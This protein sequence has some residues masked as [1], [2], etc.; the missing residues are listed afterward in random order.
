MI[1]VCAQCHTPSMV[2]RKCVNA[3]CGVVFC[4]SCSMFFCPRCGSGSDAGSLFGASGGNAARAS[5]PQ[6]T[7]APETTAQVP[8]AGPPCPACGL[9]LPSDAAVKKYPKCGHCRSDLAWNVVSR[10]SPAVPRLAQ[11]PNAAPPV[12]PSPKK[13]PAVLA[14]P[15]CGGDLPADSPAKKYRKCRNCT[16]DLHWYGDKVFTDED[17]RTKFIERQSRRRARGEEKRVEKDAEA[18][19]RDRL[20]SGGAAP[21]VP[22]RDAPPVTDGRSKTFPQALNPSGQITASAVMALRERTGMSMMN[23]KEALEA[24]GGNLELAV[25]WLSDRSSQS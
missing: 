3:A 9:P 21:Q 13:E 10:D 23:C 7:P 20:R 2:C 14:C 5:T 16:A 1:G 4:N 17:A 15:H 11:N 25:K 8:P 12:K 22:Q 19:R 24:C 18:A 6:K